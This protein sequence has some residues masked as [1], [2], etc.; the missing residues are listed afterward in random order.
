V[1]ADRSLAIS[2]ENRINLYALYSRFGRGCALA[3]LGQQEQAVIEI[4]EGIE[5]AQRSNLGYMRGFMLGWLATI[6]VE[7]DP[8]TAL[9][10]VDEALKQIND[11]AGRAWEAEL[12]RLRGD[13]LLAERPDCAEEAECNYHEAIV[14]AQHQRARSLEL[15]ATISLA[16][17]L[18]NQGRNDEARERLARIINWFTQGFDTADLREAKAL[19]ELRDASHQ[20]T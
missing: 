19:L 12:R 7:T 9:S 3:K 11:V 20:R 14:I 18:R 15:R 1:H 10:T 4:R 6:Q 5:E 8:Q 17:L 16:R 2:R 13:I